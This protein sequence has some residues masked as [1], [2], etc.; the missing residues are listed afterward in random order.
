MQSLSEEELSALSHSGPYKPPQK[1][2]QHYKDY[3][4]A[5]IVQTGFFMSKF[6]LK[7]WFY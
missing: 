6:S 7:S 1:L 3:I 5:P 2:L 4:F